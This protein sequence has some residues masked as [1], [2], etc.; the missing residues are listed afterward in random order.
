M[1]FSG[2]TY[3]VNES[4]GAAVI[5]VTR[6]GT[7]NIATSVSYA[8]SNGT[9]TAGADYTAVSGTLSFATGETSKTFSVP[10]VNDSLKEANETINLTLSNVTGS[11]ALAAPSTAVLTIIDDDPVPGIS[12]GDVSV[13]EGNSGTTNANFIV[14]LTPASGQTVT[15]NY[16]TADGTAMAPS[17]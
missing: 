11:A 8:T 17:L 10:I 12:I 9:A 15:V 5:T 1:Q 2:N 6:T 7:T 16:A 4:D 3:S 13:V 14:N